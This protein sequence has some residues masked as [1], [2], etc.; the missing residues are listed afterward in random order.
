[1]SNNNIFNKAPILKKDVGTDTCDIKLQNPKPEPHLN[2]IDFSDKIEND[3]PKLPSIRK[4]I[5]LINSDNLKIGKIL[6]GINNKEFMPEIIKQFYND[7]KKKGYV[8]LIPKKEFNTLF[9]RR[10]H[11]K[12][13]NEENSN[14]N[15]SNKEKV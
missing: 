13:K 6:E 9:L 14:S 15:N 11:K 12:Y 10:Y 1:M 2:S 5:K 8:S 4:R 3:K 7:K